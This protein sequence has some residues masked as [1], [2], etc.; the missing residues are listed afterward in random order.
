MRPTGKLTATCRPSGRDEGHGPQVMS[1]RH[2]WPL[3]LPRSRKQF[4]DNSRFALASVATLVYHA[5]MKNDIIGTLC[6]VA[7]EVMDAVAIYVG[8]LAVTVLFLAAMK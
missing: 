1:R 8:A 5:C 3:S 2:P 6:N 4:R 7:L